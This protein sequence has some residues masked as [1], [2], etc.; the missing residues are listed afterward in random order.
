MKTAG[1]LLALNDEVKALEAW[2]RHEGSLA[3]GRVADAVLKYANDHER[4]VI[5]DAEARFTKVL[6]AIDATIVEALATGSP[7]TKLA[8]IL[9]D[10][11]ALIAK[12]KP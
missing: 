5:T 3:D 6:E 11:R 10:A 12:V 1:K 4:R 8:E 2:T 9:A 7:S